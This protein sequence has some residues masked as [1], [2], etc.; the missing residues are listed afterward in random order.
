M[1]K[2]PNSRDKHFYRWLVIRHWL[3][4]TPHQDSED[5]RIGGNITEIFSNNE[6]KT[7]FKRTV[8][9]KRYFK[10]NSSKISFVAFT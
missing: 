7:K 4:K 5:A 6:R 2:E 10:S 3:Q 9:S 8:R 1:L